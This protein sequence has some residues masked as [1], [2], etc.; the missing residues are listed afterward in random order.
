MP[1]LRYGDVVC[2]V[3]GDETALDALLR[4]GVSIKHACRGGV[5]HSCLVRAAEGAPPVS[6]QVGLKQ[7]LKEQGCF[8]PCICRPDQDLVLEDPELPGRRVEALVEEMHWWRDDLLRLRLRAGS[9]FSYRAGQFVNVA[10]N[11]SLVRPYSLASVPACDDFLECHIRLHP[12]G[13][14]SQWLRE[15]MQPGD[16]VELLGPQGD[17]TYRFDEEE[18]ALL[19]I[20]TGTG[21][22]PLVGVIR[23]ALTCGHRGPILLVHGARHKEALYYV[24]ELSALAEAHTN[25]QVLRG[26]L[27]GEP[28]EGTFVG[29]LRDWLKAERP[30]LKALHKE[31]GVRSYLCGDPT[32]VKALQKLLFLGGLPLG[33]IHLDPFL[34]APRTPS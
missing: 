10:V 17:C 25:F 23:E 29:D 5:C 14:M 30:A 26:L 13:Q 9:S 19:L 2:Q 7:H 18:R 34:T 31:R 6:S 20:G 1:T 33:N 27:E 11:D 21:L 12:K 28:A 8:L 22:A 16:Q 15:Q 4:A 32:L 3:E 24:S